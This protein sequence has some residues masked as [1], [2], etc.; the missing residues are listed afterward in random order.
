VR[1]ACADARA[2]GLELVVQNGDVT[3]RD[4]PKA[5]DFLS[6]RMFGDAHYPGEV[7]WY[8]FATPL[9]AASAS[10][11]L[12]VRVNEAYFLTG[13]A[14]SALLLGAAGIFLWSIGGVPGLLT[15]PLVIAY[16]LFWPDNGVYP[17]Q[18][19]HAPLLLFL[20]VAAIAFARVGRGG[21]SPPRSAMLALGVLNGALGL[22]NGASFVVASSIS[23]ALLALLLLG[24]VRRRLR[25]REALASAGLLLVPAAALFSL[26]V[27]P[28]MVRYGA[29]HQANSARLD[30]APGYGDGKDP[31]S[32]FHLAL[33]PRDA[34]SL[35]WAA[36]FAL[37]FALARGRRWRAAP[38]LVGYVAAEALAHLGFVLHSPEHPL[39]AAAGARLLVAPAATL[40]TAGD[41][42]FSLFNLWTVA[43]A[44]AALIGRAGYRSEIAARWVALQRARVPPWLAAA[45]LA[46][47]AMPLV[48]RWP[49]QSPLESREIDARIARFAEELSMR[50]EPGTVIYG[51][52]GI[53]SLAPIKT[54][55]FESELH[56]NPYVFSER[57]R[58][59]ETLRGA[60]RRGD[61][62]T[63]AEIIDRYR[64]RYVLGDGLLARTFGDEVV[65]RTPSGDPVV[66]LS[67][68]RAP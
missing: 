6:G 1:E 22:W 27:V 37:V 67:T 13:A 68:G 35:V 32:L 34:A 8:P 55:A 44:A 63:A 64:L 12:G 19:A 29:F 39:L 18:T 31:A 59:A 11:V 60:L 49:P 58:A 33:L 2:R 50:M 26:L 10:K 57:A 21:T 43:M 66:H 23:C 15:F 54:F 3:M 9:L 46:L 4:V 42:L 24:A 28:Q 56:D 53:V 20:A 25:W 5:L 65:L 17:F 40:A 52:N 41:F 7:N 14:L 51:A 62:E 48:R 36:A 38:L 45:V 16:G 47:L 61:R 30:L